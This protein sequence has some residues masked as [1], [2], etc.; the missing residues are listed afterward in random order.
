VAGGTAC[1]GQT[2][3]VI[4]P[5]TIQRGIMKTNLFTATTTWSWIG[6]AAT[7]VG[8]LWGSYQL[9]GLFKSSDYSIEAY[10]EHQAIIV[11]SPLITSF[12]TFRN[13]INS[14]SIETMLGRENELI[15]FVTASHIRRYFDS[16]FPTEI[17]SSLKF[18]HSQWSFSIIND[19][20]K[21]IRDPSLELPF[22]GF[23]SIIRNGKESASGAFTKS[24]SL[25]AIRP[26]N[27]V[28]VIVWTSSSSD[29][30]DERQT[31]IT[32]AD[33]S[34]DIDYSVPVRGI[35]AWIENHS[36]IVLSLLFTLAII[37]AAILLA[38]FLS[39]TKPEKKGAESA[40][41]QTDN[42]NKGQNAS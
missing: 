9:L 20:S 29:A 10:G 5:L 36:P 37:L 23:Y 35:L 27:A 11:P 41:A 38:V 25:G 26:E 17:L 18:T 40:D 34:F 6:K 16:A 28:G 21:E 42:T 31:R 12:E 24:I 13:F 2:L 30:Y 14:D 8:L 3:A 7:L 33:G 39:Q 32:H 4:L 15:R 1:F 19:G 22:D